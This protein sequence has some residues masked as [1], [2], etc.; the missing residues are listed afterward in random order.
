MKMKRAVLAL[1]LCLFAGRLY[2]QQ[3][4]TGYTGFAFTSPFEISAGYDSGFLIDRTTNNDK[5]FFLSLP[6]SVQRATPLNAPQQFNE[7]VLL[8]DLPTLSFLSDSPRREMGFNYQPEFEIFR[9]NGD[10]D[11]WNHNFSAGFAYL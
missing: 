8:V 1:G 2:G 10:Q 7:E 9:Q 4:R 6:A 11:S 5:L 3:A